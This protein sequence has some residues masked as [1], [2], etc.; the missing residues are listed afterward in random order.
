[1][2]LT[3]P[4]IGAATII[5]V[6]LVSLLFVDGNAIGD[7]PL[8]NKILGIALGAFTIFFAF[9]SEYWLDFIKSDRRKLLF[10][11]VITAILAILAIMV[12]AVW[13]SGP[14]GTTTNPM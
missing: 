12:I 9:K 7:A 3:P 6:T 13:H 1:M 5:L 8:F 4:V 14:I 10:Q 11:I 2:G